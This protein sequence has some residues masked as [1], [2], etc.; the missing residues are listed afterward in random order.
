MN[1]YLVYF[2]LFFLLQS[3]LGKWYYK[4]KRQPTVHEGYMFPLLVSKELDNWPEMNTRRRKW[5]TVAEAKEICPYAWMKEALD[6]L[7]N[8]QSTKVQPKKM[9]I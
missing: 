8:R 4:S 6:E 1:S 2:G 3:K 9:E 7:V 5:I